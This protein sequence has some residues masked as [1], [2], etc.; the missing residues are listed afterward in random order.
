MRVA[1][2]VAVAASADK[3]Y[4]AHLPDG[5]IRVLEGT[6]ALIWSHALTVPRSRLAAALLDEVEGDPATISEGASAFVDSLLQQ[7]LLVDDGHD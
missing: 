4:L 1:P 5:P 2:L 7:G 6:A 3:V